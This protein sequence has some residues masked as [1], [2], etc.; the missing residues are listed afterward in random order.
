MKRSL[1]LTL[2]FSLFLG[3]SAVAHDSLVGQFPAEGQTLE[4]GVI[5]VSLEFSD[6]VLAI[7]GSSATEIIISGP[8]GQESI[9][10]NGCALVEGNSAIARVELVEPG[11]YQVAWRTVSN[12]GHPISGSYAFNIEN[13]TG[14]QAQGFEEI[15]CANLIS[16]NVD[17]A[18]QNQDSI[19]YLLLWISLP[20][21][22]VGI[23]ILVWPKNK[24]R[25]KK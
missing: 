1:I 5:E 24:S 12:D 6:E 9:R 3:Q 22:A 20:L 25:N 18:Q 19:N 15:Q 14:Y 21:L 16:Q 8:A 4:A 11:T 2:L 7:E 10:N 17:L 13:T 23:L